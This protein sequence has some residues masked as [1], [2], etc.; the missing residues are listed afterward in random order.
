MEATTN[1]IVELIKQQNKL[2]QEIL[3][4]SKLET[5]TTATLIQEQKEK[6]EA[7]LKLKQVEEE[8]IKVEQ[9]KLKEIQRSNETQR[10]LISVVESLLKKVNFSIVLVAI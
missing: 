7:C 8:R 3:E 10:Q 2:N 1:D 5:A 6:K 9:E 4:A